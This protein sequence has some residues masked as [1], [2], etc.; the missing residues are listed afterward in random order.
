MCKLLLMTKGSDV[1]RLF[2]A[3]VSQ[4]SNAGCEFYPGYPGLVISGGQ[5][6]SMAWGSRSC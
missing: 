5:L 2:S 3:T 4:I 6:R 1:A